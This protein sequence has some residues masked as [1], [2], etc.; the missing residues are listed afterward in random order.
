MMIR[1][2][3][4]SGEA[5]PFGAFERVGISRADVQPGLDPRRLV[6]NSAR[7]SGAL[8]EGMG[9]AQMAVLAIR[10]TEA[11]AFLDVSVGRI[12]G[13]L[14]ARALMLVVVVPHMLGTVGLVPAIV[15]CGCECELHRQHGEH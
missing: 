9:C 1:N 4:E 13:N 5:S 15:R 3:A 11:R 2:L 8:Q 6:G 10:V 7:C 12:R 14:P